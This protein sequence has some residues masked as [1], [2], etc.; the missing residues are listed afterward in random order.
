MRKYNRL[1]PAFL[2]LL[3]G[4]TIMLGIGQRWVDMDVSDPWSNS[5]AFFA[6]R[7][8]VDLPEHALAISYSD[9]DSFALLYAVNCGITDPNNGQRLLPRPDVDAI[10]ANWVRYDWFYEYVN[11]RWGRYG[12]VRFISPSHERDVALR[13][14][15]DQ[16][17]KRR[18]VVVTMDVLGIIESQRYHYDTIPI[19]PFFFRVVALEPPIVPP[20]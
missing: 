12:R 4:A 3:V 16:N 13:H 6:T 9:G 1:L 8:L 15:V 17:L 10:V 7:A 11:E 20:Q 18:P 2:A 19:S 14:L 5:A